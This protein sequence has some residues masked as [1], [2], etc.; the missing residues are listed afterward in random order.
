[1]RVEGIIACVMCNVCGE[2]GKADVSVCR[3]HQV[4]NDHARQIR[5]AGAVA[6]KESCLPGFVELPLYLR[7]TDLLLR[8]ID[9]ILFIA[10]CRERSR[11]SPR[12]PPEVWID[13]VNSGALIQPSSKAG[14]G[15]RLSFT[16]KVIP[17]ELKRS[18][19]P[20]VGLL[21]CRKTGRQAYRRQAR[22]GH[23]STRYT[24]ATIDQLK[25]ETVCDLIAR[26][27]MY[28]YQYIFL[29]L[30]RDLTFGINL[31]PVKDARVVVKM[32]LRREQL[33]FGKRSSGMN[34][35]QIL[36][37]QSL[38]RT[39]PSESEDIACFD[40][41][42]LMNVIDNIDVVRIILRDDRGS[43]TEARR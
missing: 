8:R 38:L 39:R 24:A 2:G 35:R 36:I 21:A 23:R 19:R 18:A 33:C 29:C 17:R 22:Q 10:L 37:D 6:K 26:R 7:R 1:M 34:G 41:W 12:R 4:R 31:G 32:T 40:L 3:Q 14:K 13:I 5:L 43:L 11:G 42:S 28:S 20:V 27:L 9:G 16:P 30:R 15:K 25:A